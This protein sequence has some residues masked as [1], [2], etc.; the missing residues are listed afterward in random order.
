MTRFAEE[1]N[2]MR[3]DF[4]KKEAEKEL[5]RVQ[6]DYEAGKITIDENGIAR[7]CI[8]RILMADM[9]EKLALVTDEVDVEEFFALT[10]EAVYGLVGFLRNYDGIAK[11][12]KVRKQYQGSDFACI[13]DRIDDVIYEYDHGAAGRIYNMQKLLEC[14][15]YPE[16]HGVFRLKCIDEFPQNNGI[17]EVEYQNGKATVTKRA[18]GDYDISL[19]A[20]A[21]A[22]LMLAGEGHDSQ[23]A[24]YIDGV[25]IK[26]NADAFF[27]AFPYRHTRFADSSWSI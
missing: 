4:W 13:A 21:A 14:N 7:N 24:L 3:G 20:C 22:R 5:A 8:G 2:G 25:E 9:L 19:T 6:A 17:F 16:E 27:K 26:G 10:P 1:L 15:A 11:T 18:E 12:L 23:S